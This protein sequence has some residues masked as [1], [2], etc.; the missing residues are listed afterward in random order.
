[1]LISLSLP[2][3]FPIKINPPIGCLKEL[4]GFDFEMFDLATLFKSDYQ[5]K[6]LRVCGARQVSLVVV[7][8]LY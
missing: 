8:N 5:I 4:L 1:M 3:L 2:P 6:V 7:I